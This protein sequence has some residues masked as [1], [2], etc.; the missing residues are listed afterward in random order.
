MTGVI[1]FTERSLNA[2]KTT[3]GAMT[4]SLKA[5]LGEVK[6]LLSDRSVT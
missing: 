4:D 3:S 6:L 2:T 5:S 1:Y